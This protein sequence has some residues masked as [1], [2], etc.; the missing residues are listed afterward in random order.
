M[1]PGELYSPEE[2]RNCIP[3][4]WFALI[5]DPKIAAELMRAVLEMSTIADQ[6]VLLVKENCPEEEFVAYRA[7][8]GAVMGELYEIV[9]P[10]SVAHPSIR[11]PGL[12]PDLDED[13]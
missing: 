3:E 6:S 13:R 5:T 7:R 1:P 12:F 9:W 4:R 10:L 2:R 11:P 8:I